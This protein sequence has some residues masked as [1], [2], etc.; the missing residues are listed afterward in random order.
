MDLGVLSRRC[1]AFRQDADAAAF[2]TIGQL[3]QDDGSA[4]EAALAAPALADRPFEPGLDRRRG[5]VDVMA[6]EAK[7]GLEPQRIPGAE[8]DRRDLRLGQQAPRQRLGM[9]I[10]D[11]DLPAILAGI[12]GAREEA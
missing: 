6:V 4:G 8:P 11:R 9:V 5:Q 12:A 1:P 10:L 3:L 7:P 2:G